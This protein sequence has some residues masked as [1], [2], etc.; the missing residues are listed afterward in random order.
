M[1]ISNILG[2][3]FKNCNY[4]HFKC[5]VYILYSF[6]LI[7]NL[8]FVDVLVK[9]KSIKRFPFKR[10]K[11]H[12]IQKKPGT[13]SETN[14][15]IMMDASGAGAAPSSVPQQDQKKPINKNLHRP[16]HNC[17]SAAG[18]LQDQKYQSANNLKI[19][20]ANEFSID[21]R[22]RSSSAPLTVEAISVAD[23]LTRLSDKLTQSYIL[24]KTSIT[25]RIR[26]HTFGSPKDKENE[27]RS[28]HFDYQNY[29][30]MEVECLT[31]SEESPEFM[32]G[33][34]V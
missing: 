24:Q 1:V 25:N 15:C 33:T 4:S 29:E 9:T 31:I 30:H 22:R 20:D 26:R 5:Y 16:L 13:C 10:E 8:Y 32:R 27:R 12:V 28:F 6:C 2:I 18:R 34:S 7:I 3:Y 23:E 11:K 14:F 19:S 21:H 17:K